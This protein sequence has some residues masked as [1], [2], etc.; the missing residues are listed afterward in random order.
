MRSR[1][2]VIIATALFIAA[3]LAVAQTGRAAGPPVLINEVLVGNS[4]VNLDPDYTNYS[5]W[6]ELLNTTAKPLKLTG[7]RV[8]FVPDG[9]TTPLEHTLRGR[10][11]VP[12]HGHFL[13]WADEEGEDNHTSFDLDMDGGVLTL[14]DP[15]G[16][17]MD[18]VAVDEQE[19]DVAYG[20]S[21]DGGATWSYF[22]RP[23]PGTANIATPYAAGDI[24]AAPEFSKDGGLWAGPLTVELTSPDAGAT[25]RYTTDGSR[26]VDTSPLYTGPIA[27]NATTVLRARAWVNGLMKSPTATQTYLL[28][29]P[30]N[31][32][33]VSVVTDPDNLWNPRFGIYTKGSNGIKNCN[34][35]AN[36]HQSWERPASIEF[37]ETDGTNRLN[38]E[39]G[40]EIFGN[41]TRNFAR[42]SF[43]IK[44]KKLYGDNDMDYAFF[45]DKPM[46]SYKRILLRNSGQDH[47]NALMR[48]ALSAELVRGRMDI[49]RMAYRPAIVYLNGV[50]W[51]IY[52]LRE[53]MDEDYVENNFGV[54]EDEIDVLEQ[55]GLLVSGDKTAW[56]D[57]LMFVRT[58]DVDTPAGYAQL[59][60]RLDVNEFMNY[61]IPHMYAGVTSWPKR[62]TRYWD[63]HGDAYGWRWMLRDLDSGFEKKGIT[64]DTINWAMRGG[65]PTSALFKQL[66]TNEAF[67][68]EFA[69]RFAAHLNTTYYPQ[70][71]ITTIDA[72][73][74][75]IDDEMPAHIA[76]WG[77][78]ASMAVW[79]SEVDYLRYFATV[80]PPYLWDDLRDL[81][82]NAPDETLTIHIDGNGHVLVAGVEVPDGYSGPHFRGV[83]MTLTAVPGPGAVFDRWL[84]TGE[85]IESITI[86]FTG[87]TTRTAVFETIPLPPIVINELHHTPAGP[88]DPNDNL[89]EFL[90]LYNA[91][92]SAVD[93]SGFSFFG[94]TF[95]FPNGASIAPGE[96][97][98]VAD[99]PASYT[100]NGYQVFDFSGGLS[101]G[102]ET[103]TLL[104][105]LGNPVDTVEYGVA[106]LWPSSPNGGG[107]SLSLINPALDNSLP[108][109]WAASSVNGGTPGAAN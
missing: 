76:R 30:T 25:I 78:P 40:L 43:E 41:C 62:N 46:T 2:Y 54:D 9:E 28:G 13:I 5:G 11:V 92:T 21:P 17:V 107:P 55:S 77:A 100:G 1:S 106:G 88:T 47:A 75:A 104:D 44:A 82:K 101:S 74:D 45:D 81:F 65:G 53:K 61:L 60:T 52:D 87:P 79:E 24:A 68:A 34:V 37:Y 15:K 35:T 3:F 16:V 73:Q 71:V 96:Y 27:I 64:Q 57:F 58:L 38:Q 22:D 51:G 95:T 91:G 26:P 72:M 20:R 18:T 83:P 66:L 8:R 56:L 10:V 59:Q 89:Y 84:E 108:G 49:D 29:V 67:R 32:P 42:K 85:T 86:P 33:I 109:S 105:G 7:Y 63:D 99:N 69:Q 19:P 102:G 36:W 90:E 31:L 4:G 70:R 94:V 6:I 97:I 50:Y 23:T 93:L 12:A 80:R 103:I 98:V 48:D 14:L 39:V